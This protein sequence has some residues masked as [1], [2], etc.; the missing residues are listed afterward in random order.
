M[1][2]KEL[3]DTTKDEALKLGKEESAIF[4]LLLHFSKKNGAE[5]YANINDIV[6]E[7][8]YKS[9]SEAV[10]RYL[11]DNVPVQHITGIQEFFGYDFN[12]DNTVLI[13]RP[14]TEE[15][16]ENILLTYDEFMD[17]DVDVV[18]IGCGSG[19]IGITL[20]LE[21]PRMNVTLTD[22]SFEAIE[23][24][25]ENADKLGADVK[26]LQGDML[27]PLEGMKFDILV[28]NPPYIPTNEEIQ[29]LVIV[30]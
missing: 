17:H 3:Y 30:N 18:D 16:V 26:F 19:C 27:K 28:S 25:K 10:K 5:F 11:Y 13:P 8:T 24:A 4:I 29:S 21:E 23:K 1:T 14:E 12:V 22:I 9:F 15:L 20:K 6:D 2:Y 7:D